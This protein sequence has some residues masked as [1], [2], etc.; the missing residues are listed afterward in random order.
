[1]YRLYLKTKQPLLEIFEAL[2]EPHVTTVSFVEI[3]DKQAAWDSQDWYI[4][5]FC[6]NP[7]D[8]NF[9]RQLIEEM[10]A[11][12]GLALPELEITSFEDKNWL[13]NMWKS[14][15]PQRVGSF[16]IHGDGYVDE[17]PA[18]M[19]P[20][21]LHAATAFGSGEHGTTAGCMIAIEESYRE[22]PWSTPLDL[23]CGSGILSVAMAKLHRIPVHAIDI[24]PEAVRVTKENAL[25][26]GVAPLILAEEGDGLLNNERIFDFIVANILAKPL[27]DLAP[28]VKSHLT[29]QGR[30]ILSGL[31]DWQEEEVLG[32]YLE[33]GFVLKDKKNI[34]RWITLVLA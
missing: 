3:E 24:D 22:K 12:E 23:G 33:Q 25:K 16:F 7:I 14:F 1:M 5:G 6:E 9:L 2:I 26:N 34:N 10:C 21:H 15:P 19:I 29:P 31:L 17:I 11:Q 13:E 27:I 8:E 4:E 28:K 20:I 18:H 32:A 30:V